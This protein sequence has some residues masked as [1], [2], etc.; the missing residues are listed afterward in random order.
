MR[1]L[2]YFLE[3]SDGSHRDESSISF[4]EAEKLL[5]GMDWNTLSSPLSPSCPLPLTAMAQSADSEVD[6]PF[7]L[8]L[9]TGE[10]FFMIMPEIEGLLI[11]ARVLDKWNLLGLL[12]KE[13]A[14]TLNFGVLAIEDSLSLL[15]L[16]FEDKY[17]AM[18]SLEKAMQEND[19][20]G[21]S[22]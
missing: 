20:L 3:L 8:F 18:R 16:F 14:F 7:M 15:K 4:A 22:P 2:R 13:K 17:P 5:R 10:S 6:C 19:R 21:P 9:D 1:K 11:T 12:E